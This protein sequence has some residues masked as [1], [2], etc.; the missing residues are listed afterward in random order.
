MRIR[1]SVDDGEGRLSLASSGDTRIAVKSD[2]VSSKPYDGSYG[3]V[4]SVEAQV[5]GTAGRLMERDFVVAPIPSNYGLVEYDG[6]G[7][8]V[9]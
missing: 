7:L 9:S 3:A 2:Y 6:T 1:L 5:F 8:S 4:P